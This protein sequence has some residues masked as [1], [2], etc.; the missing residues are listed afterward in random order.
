MSRAGGVFSDLDSLSVSLRVSLSPS[1]SPLSPSPLRPPL[2]PLPSLST[3]SSLLFFL[4]S[5]F[6][7]ASLNLD[8]GFVVCFSFFPSFARGQMF[9][10]RPTVN[11]C[12]S[13]TAVCVHTDFFDCAFAANTSPS[14]SSVVSEADGCCLVIA[15]GL[16]IWR[17]LKRRLE[18]KR[19][20]EDF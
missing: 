15:S 3:L 7:F 19:C 5:A 1:L 9:C 4:S 2:L 14:S 11:S 8:G 12:C 13:V 16:R 6:C 20:G 18:G 17:R 10:L